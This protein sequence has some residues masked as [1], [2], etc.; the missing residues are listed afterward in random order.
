MNEEPASKQEI[1][2]AVTDP[3]EPEPGAAT[4]HQGCGS[5]QRMVRLIDDSIVKSRFLLAPD[6]LP[7]GTLMLDKDGHLHCS[8]DPNEFFR[9][10]ACLH[11]VP[12]LRLLKV[13]E[14]EI[15]G[16]QLTSL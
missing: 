14:S 4:E 7:I 9:L 11:P 5:L 12:V 15:V 10:G 3:V 8:C 1:A 2:H 16:Y 6:G 13:G